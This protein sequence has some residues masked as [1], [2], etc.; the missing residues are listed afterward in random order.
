MRAHCKPMRDDRRD[1]RLHATLRR[2]APITQTTLDKDG[3]GRRAYGR[4]TMLGSAGAGGLTDFTMGGRVTGEAWSLNPYAGC[5]HACSYCYVPDTIHAERRR[6]GT[7]VIVK[8]DLATRLARAMAGSPKRTVYLSTATDPY[9]APEA[10]HEIT[11]RCLEVLVRRDWPVEILTRSPLVQ[12]DL[13][14]IV[15]LS[16]VRVGFSVPTLDDGLRQALEPA[17]PAVG[18]RLK[19]LRRISDEGVPTFANHTP[20]CPPTTHDADAVAAAFL[21]AGAQWVNSTRWKRR[22]TTIAPVWERLRG[23]AWEETVRFF[24]SRERQA[25]WHEELG[26]A[27]CRVGLPLG[28]AFYNPPFEWMQEPPARGR[29]PRL[30]DPWMLPAV[31]SVPGGRGRGP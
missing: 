20:A 28:T 11:R 31:A 21:D 7:Y 4:A 24:A 19:A 26:R 8:H 15:R 17:A 27:F 13:D 2:A 23:T 16:Q 25:A 5:A 9:Q 10:E 22:A 18:A 12:R 29:Q 30:D 1:D 6:W 3:P 14:L